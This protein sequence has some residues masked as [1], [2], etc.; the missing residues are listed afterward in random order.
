MIA[1]SFPILKDPSRPNE[2]IIVVRSLVPG[3]VAQLDG[4]LMPG[5]RL[6]FV[7]DVRLER[8]TQAEA[9]RALKAAA[10]GRVRIGVA[11]LLP[12]RD[13]FKSAAQVGDCPGLSGLLLDVWVFGGCGGLS[14]LSLDV[15]VFSGCGGLSW[16]SLD[17]WVFGGC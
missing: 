16:L 9:A 7:N 8:A 12:L 1:C 14:W 17:V 3:G 15:W 6:L 2:T 4:R 13:V 11:K 5:D 10:Q